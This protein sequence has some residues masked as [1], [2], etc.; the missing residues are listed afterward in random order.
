VSVLDKAGH[1]IAGNHDPESL[2]RWLGRSTGREGTMW[3]GLSAAAV[4]LLVAA[5]LWPTAPRWSLWAVAWTAVV[6]VIWVACVLVDR[7][8][9]RRPR[10]DADSY[11]P[12]SA[13]GQVLGSARAD[14]IRLTES[15]LRAARTEAIGRRAVTIALPAVAEPWP[16]HRD[17]VSW[18]EAPLPPARHPCWPQTI[19]VYATSGRGFER[20]PCG[21]VRAERRVSPWRRRNERRREE[22]TALEPVRATSPV[23]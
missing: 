6:V 20:C 9:G 14:Q 16:L 5:A 21:A 3:P 15:V 11:R 13:A 18:H 19:G 1:E 23:E 12:G 22:T 8:P 2:H 10:L 17:G 7:P 4:A